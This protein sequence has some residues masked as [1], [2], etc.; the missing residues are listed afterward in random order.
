MGGI[1]IHMVGAIHN[2]IAP[3]QDIWYIT[4]EYIALAKLH[5]FDIPNDVLFKCVKRYCSHLRYDKNINYRNI[6]Q[7]LENIMSNFTLMACIYY[8]TKDED[9]YSRFANKW[10][11]VIKN[12]YNSDKKRIFNIAQFTC[13]LSADRMRYKKNTSFKK[14]NAVT[15]GDNAILCHDSNFLYTI[16]K[17]QYKKTNYICSKSMIKNVS[18]T[19]HCHSDD[20]YLTVK[21]NCVKINHYKNITL[22]KKQFTNGCCNNYNDLFNE[23]C[24]SDDDFDHF[25]DTDSEEESSVKRLKGRVTHSNYK[26]F[27]VNGINI[28][29]PE[30]YEINEIE[31]EYNL[32]L[33]KEDI[34]QC[35][36]NISIIEN[37]K[38][39][40]YFVKNGFK[41]YIIYNDDLSANY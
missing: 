39:I 14:C 8:H 35:Y 27:S 24:P 36:K 21:D 18:I 6:V 10:F 30:M 12:N 17:W 16:E 31:I 29:K 1:L 23:Y 41:F 20:S 9:N 7:Q 4:C 37:G 19:A 32:I 2:A 28:S 40:T 13:I 33:E 5:N 3:P 25:Y 11:V 38:I 15:L 22:D 34:K 26:S